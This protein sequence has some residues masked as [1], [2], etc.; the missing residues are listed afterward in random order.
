MCFMIN[1][2]NITQSWIHLHKGQCGLAWKLM[3]KMF[4]NILKAIC[5][6]YCQNVHGFCLKNVER[7]LKC[8]YESLLSARAD[9]E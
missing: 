6:K 5:D 8:S 3:V 9:R 1:R 2:E 7:N 4:Q